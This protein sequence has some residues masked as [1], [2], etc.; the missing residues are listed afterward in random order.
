MRRTNERSHSKVSSQDES[1]THQPPTLSLD[2]RR[3]NISFRL[4][5]SGIATVVCFAVNLKVI[6]V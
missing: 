4:P 3:N 6:Y 5:T 1:A 2:N